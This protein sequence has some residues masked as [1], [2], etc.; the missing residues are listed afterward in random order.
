VDE[1]LPKQVRFAEGGR[2][3]CAA[4]GTQNHTFVPVRCLDVDTGRV[5]AEAASVKRAW[6][7]VA[8]S[9]S[10]RVVISQYRPEPENIP[11]TSVVDRRVVW[12]FRNGQQVAVWR[13]EFQKWRFPMGKIRQWR[14]NPFVFAISPTG[15]YIAEG[16][17]GVLRLFEIEP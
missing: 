3:F 11:T 17:N 13:P 8:A 7:I 1:I 15:K 16:G 6:S 4:A 14:S 9:E 2:T 5:I 10:S 12:D